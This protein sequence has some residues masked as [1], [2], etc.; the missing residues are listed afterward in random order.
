[1]DAPRP[2]REIA[3]YRLL[4]KIGEGG[5]GVVWKAEDTTLGRLVAIKFLPRDLTAD[6]ARRERFRREARSAAALAHPNIAVIHE[7]GE[8]EGSLFL[9]MELIRGSP[10]RELLREGPLPLRDLLDLALPMAEALEHAHRHGIVHRDL[11]PDNVMITAE[12]KVKLLDFGL[13]KPLH[14]VPPAD[15]APSGTPTLPADLTVEGTLA[16][17]VAYMS[18]EAAQGRPADARSDIFSFGILLYEMAAGKRPFQ[19]GTW[20]STLAKILEEAPPPL[21]DHRPDLPPE[22]VA[23]VGR[24]L[25][26]RPEDRYPG[27]SELAADLG[28]LARTISAGP[29]AGRRPRARRGLRRAVAAVLGAALAAALIWIAYGRL[30]P[31]TGA[32]PPPSAPPA[33][34][35]A[36]AAPVGVAVL[37][38]AVRGAGQFAYLGEGIVNLLGAALDGAG[39]VRS[40]DARA[41]LGAVQ[42]EGPETLDPE[43]AGILARRLG[44]ARFVLG[45]VVEAGG[46]LRIQTAVYEAEESPRPLAT[47]EAEGTPEEVFGMVDALAAR[48][49]AAQPGGPSARVSRVAAVTT[50]SIQALKAYLEGEAHFRAGRFVA[51]AEAFERAVEVDPTFA[52]AYYRLSIAT[53]WGLS[54]GRSRDAAEK[55]VKHGDRLSP[56]DRLLLEA[57]LAWR[58]GDADEA[59]RLY[60][61]VLGS[62]PDDVEAWFQLGEVLFHAGP[63]RGR[64]IAESREPFERVLAFEP[65]HVP[66]LLHLARV[67]AGEKRTADL[68]DLVN[69]ALRHNPEGERAL[70]AKGLL[71]YALGDRAAQQRVLEEARTVTDGP[72]TVSTNMVIFTGDLMRSKEL[73]GATAA[74]SRAPETR[75]VGH[76][77]LAQVE[78]A[79]GRFAAARAELQAA[80]RLDP[81]WGLEYRAW[82]ALLP[83][84]ETPRS[85]IASLHAELS[86]LVPAAI[87]PS[88]S[89]NTWVIVHDGL[90][91][92]IRLYLLGLA[93]IRLGRPEEALERAAALE[94]HPVPETAASF[95]TNLARSLRAEAALARGRK[96]EALRLLDRPPRGVPYIQAFASPFYSGPQDRYLLAALLAESGR[97]AEALG[98]YGS[99][100]ESAIHELPY[101]GPSHL[102][103]AEILERLGRGP[104]AAEQRARFGELWKQADPEVRLR[105]ETSAGASGRI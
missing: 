29:A 100:S 18:P 97:A 81:A 20:A 101:V 4:E 85:E 2:G 34:A 92:L 76:V 67:A 87:P 31:R 21:R 6:P 89:T 43:T 49:L 3:H 60:R 104:E 55:A 63:L 32:S 77:R 65:E 12:R 7:I 58:R 19:G 28:D 80:G 84:L 35:A 103:R 73:L 9:V 51:A 13:A 8:H 45:D 24:C 37:P 16:G 5:M 82:L 57:M 66:S 79:L 102:R 71:A 74:P 36:S 14:A 72:L 95:G 62:Y 10:L 90:H 40:V 70:E 46:R 25:E 42:R 23:I 96:D 61:T 50:G 54:G 105:L 52:L 26:K 56:H 11:K 53:E 94:K 83:F 48:I 75:L 78:A 22:L 27:A 91:P 93:E 99:F 64:S 59:E 17:T 86:R 68:E 30:A 33:P 98:L 15:G 41:V 88:V 44:A 1:V 39:P 38:F 69:R 47:A